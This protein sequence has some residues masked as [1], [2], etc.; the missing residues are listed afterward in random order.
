LKLAKLK[1]KIGK[2]PIVVLNNR[3]SL[4][5]LDKQFEII[6]GIDLCDYLDS[7]KEK[8]GKGNYII[9]SNHHKCHRRFPKV[10]IKEPFWSLNFD[11]SLSHKFEIAKKLFLPQSQ[12]KNVIQR[13]CKKVDFVGFI[14]VDGLS[15]VDCLS[16]EQVEPCL[17]D[18][19]TKTEFGFRNIVGE[20]KTIA[21]LLFENGYHRFI[22]FS[23]WEKDENEL[24]KVLFKGFPVV[25]KVNS[26]KDV[27][28]RLEQT[29]LNKT[30]F[31]VVT[32]GLDGLAH[33]C[34]EEPLIDALVSQLKANI[35]SIVK[36]LT[37]TKLK[38]IVYISSDHGILWK[39]RKNLKKVPFE[40]AKNVYS[41]RCYEGTRAGKQGLCFSKYGKNMISVESPYILRELRSDEWG[42]HGGISL[43]ESITP[44]LAIK[45]N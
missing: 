10:G 22:G 33:K 6:D 2:I 9:L 8:L 44:F 16:W 12:I 11:E 1:E 32:S 45:I 41:P 42:V 25:S 38:G 36:A 5:C 39:H 31:Q 40:Y 23:Y 3:E 24:T 26:L 18:T 29:P 19:L 15:Y 14:I 27:K 43:E 20:T 4:L 7:P 17:V 37:L 30:Y 13:N 28:K 21:N 34:R 35:D